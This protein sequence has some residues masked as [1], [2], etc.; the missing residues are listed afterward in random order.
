MKTILVIDDSP[1]IRAS[2]EFAVKPIGMDV[3][4]AENGKKGLEV[5]S[6]LNSSGAE[7]GLVIVDVT[8]LKWME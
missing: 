5:F 1:T 8:C 2:V 3:K 4:Q 6:S 7:L